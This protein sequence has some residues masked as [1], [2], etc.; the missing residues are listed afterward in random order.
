MFRHSIFP[1]Q[2]Q[3]RKINDTCCNFIKTIHMQITYRIGIIPTAEQIIDVYL[4]AGLNRPTSPERIRK[5]YAHSNLV[6]TAWDVE[7][8]AGVCR[9]M[10]DHA[11]SCYLSDLAVHKDYQHQGI[12]TRLIELTRKEIGEEVML[13]LLA[14]PGAAAYYPRIGFTKWEDSFIIHRKKQD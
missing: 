7:K 11:W 2:N 9:A 4:N 12:G 10:T 8:L 3:Y 1:G 13:V 5:M 14:V 6:I